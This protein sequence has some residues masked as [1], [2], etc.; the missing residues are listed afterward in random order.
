MSDSVILLVLP[1]LRQRDLAQTPQ[2]RHLLASG[3]LA[4]LAPGF[5]CLSGPAQAAMLTGTTPDRHGIVADAFYLRDHR[6][7]LRPSSWSACLEQATI[8][9]ALGEYQPEALTAAWLSPFAAAGEPS[10]A[11]IADGDG[12]QIRPKSLASALKAIETQS[13]GARA[14]PSDGPEAIAAAVETARRHHPQFFYLCLDCLTPAAEQFGPDSRELHASLAHLDEL[15][16]RLAAGFAEAYGRPSPLWLVTGGFT[17]SPVDHVAFP[18]R[19]L[20]EAG[21]LTLKETPEGPAIDS[22]RS[23]AWAAVNRQMS[24]IYVAERS[25]QLAERAAH[26][27]ARQPGIAE[28]LRGEELA[29]YDLRHERSGDVVLVSSPRSWQAHPWWSSDAEGPEWS[30]S[31]ASPYQPGADPSDAW[32]AVGS[33]ALAAAREVKGSHGAPAREEAQRSFI[34]SSEPGVLAGAVLADTDVFDLV[35]RQFGI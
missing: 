34:A 10:L 18:N 28:A 11:C 7:I 12:W 15:V 3:D 14:E 9:Q 26:L 17:I 22:E 31:V 20:R 35:L 1:G 24:H 19:I 13:G 33:S 5:P 4:A 2:L 6:Q 21:L 25:A 23:Q 29:K 27:F 16:G 8:W 30:C 32:R